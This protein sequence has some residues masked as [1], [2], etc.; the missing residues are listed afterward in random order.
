MEEISKS[1]TKELPLGPDSITG[2]VIVKAENLDAAQKMA[3]SNLY[4]T[5]IRVYEMRT[6]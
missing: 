1:G 6:R 4:I 5:S 3:Q 2:Y